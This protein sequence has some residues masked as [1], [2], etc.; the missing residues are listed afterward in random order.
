MLYLLGVVLRFTLSYF[1]RHGPTVQ[2]DESLYINIAKS[3]AAGEGIAYRSQPVPY[4]Y[5]FYPL[6]LVPLYLFPLP[7][8]LYR[9]VQF[10]NAL[11]I[12]T[13]VFPV[14]L[15]AKDFTGDKKK[16]LLAASLT[17][18]M[19]DLQM[20]GYQMAESAVWPLSL[21]LVFFAGRLFLSE[22]RRLLNG[23][24]SG[25][26]TALLFWTKPGAIAMGLSLL[27]CALF[28]GEQ[29]ERKKRR[30]AALAGLAVCAGMIV[31]FYALYALA[32]GYDL[33]LLGLY[34]KQLTQTSA[35]WF[36]A[37]ADCSLL[38][39]VLFAVSCAGV[40][41]VVPF[42]CFDGY[43]KPHKTF[44]SAFTAG[45]VVTAIG[46]AAFVDMF[47]WNGSFTNPQLHLRYMAMFVPVMLVFFLSAPLPE[48]KNSLL[49]ISFAVM[50]VLSVFPGGSVG[51]VKEE[52][53]YIDSL[54]LSAWLSDFYV[55]PAAGIVLTVVLA[56]FLAFLSLQAFRGRFSPALQKISL[57][58]FSLFLLCNTVCGYIAGNSH[59]DLNG[60]GADAMEM[61]SILEELPQDVLIVTRQSYDHPVSF[62]LESRIR[63][64]YQQV[65]ADALAEALA[66]SDG[67]YTPFIPEDRDPNVGNHLTP[68]TDTFLFGASAAN[69]IE[70]P[71]AASLQ[72]SRNENYTLVQL[73]EGSRL[74]DTILSGPDENNILHQE[75]EAALYIFN[76]SLYSNGKLSLSLVAY[77]EE[78]S[79]TLLVENAGR[80]QTVS[81][82]S[83]PF[84]YRLSLRE[85]DVSITARGGDAVIITYSTS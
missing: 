66:G 73:P 74:A 25:F 65:S 19:P 85:G 18:L 46:V 40:I 22:D 62:F 72:K 11:L 34:N 58:F 60:Y 41:F 45:L 43:K 4:L 61:N 83:R 39:L 15:F 54:S 70:F 57:V 26:F 33:S 71:D 44:F 47:L 6:L 1:F 23:I 38:Q 3:L 16:S 35:V 42:A 82:S 55:P 50:A 51:F 84:A 14:Y 48:G 30:G 17:L 80:Q 7:F 29:E 67:F 59:P 12:T 64:P 76:D 81:L 10:Y 9:V 53:T 52:S 37:V 21:W 36:A 49:A 56:L 2:I 79:A 5:I 13:S 31:L 32:F 8:D 69:L 24:L 63:K 27:L 20:A 75:E 68:D 78:G 28:S 77:A